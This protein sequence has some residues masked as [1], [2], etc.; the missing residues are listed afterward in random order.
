MRQWKRLEKDLMRRLVADFP[1]ARV[2]ALPSLGA[3]S[4]ASA[5]PPSP[6]TSAHSAAANLQSLQHHHHHHNIATNDS[7]HTSDLSQTSGGSSLPATSNLMIIKQE[8]DSFLTALSAS[9]VDGFQDRCRQYDDELKKLSAKRVSQPW[10]ME[11]EKQWFLV[12]ESM[13]FSYE[14]MRQPAEAVV[15]YEELRALL[16]DP[17]HK[18]TTQDLRQKRDQ[19]GRTALQAALQGDS[20]AFRECIRSAESLAAVAYELQHYLLV[21]ET[22][23]FF[24]MNQPTGAIQRCRKFVVNMFQWKIPR[25][26]TAG[27]GGSPAPSPTAGDRNALIQANTW[28]F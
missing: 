24:A 5:T 11:N 27:S 26:L 20:V 7:S 14:Q 18:S 19:H 2:C 10:S 8:F 6:A 23:Q 15:Q 3:G 4:T 25:S 13:A 16:P 12:K 22:T 21:R 9:V 28:A 1:A 17:V